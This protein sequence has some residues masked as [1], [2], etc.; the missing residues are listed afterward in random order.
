MDMDE[1]PRVYSILLNAE[2]RHYTTIIF[3]EDQKDRLR[4]PGYYYRSSRP[5]E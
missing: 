4:S 5:G 2:I 3:Q 1:V